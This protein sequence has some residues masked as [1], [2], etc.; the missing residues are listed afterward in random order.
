MTRES[1]LNVQWQ[2]D[3]G[4]FGNATI[5]LYTSRS[6]FAATRPLHFR[7]ARRCNKR[8]LYCQVILHGPL[9]VFLSKYVHCRAAYVYND[10]FV[11][12]N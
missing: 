9:I 6:G 11:F 1:Q 10:K 3:E 8:I 7:T 12:L 4:H 2:R 5:E